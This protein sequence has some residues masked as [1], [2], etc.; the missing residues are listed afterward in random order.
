MKHHVVFWYNDHGAHVASATIETEGVDGVPGTER[1]L[2]SIRKNCHDTVKASVVIMSWQ[3]LVEDVPATEEDFPGNYG[4]EVMQREKTFEEKRDEG[5]VRGLA[6]HA[7]RKAAIEAAKH[8]CRDCDHMPKWATVEAP[9]FC[10]AMGILVTDTTRTT[11][12]KFVTKGTLAPEQRCGDCLY[13]HPG[14]CNL[15]GRT[16]NA[17]TIG[18][19]GKFNAK[20]VTP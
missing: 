20:E 7:R 12:R 1:W 6:E 14:G 10:K 9:E 5:V 19:C 11:C 15:L 16:V 8:N 18:R 17:N 3:E 2:E 4:P 13:L